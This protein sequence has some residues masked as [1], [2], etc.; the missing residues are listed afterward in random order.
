[1]THLKQSMLFF[2]ITTSF[3]G[4]TLLNSASSANIVLFHIRA[5]VA[6]NSEG[7]SIDD[8]EIVKSLIYASIL[9][10]RIYVVKSCI[11]NF[12]FLFTARLAMTTQ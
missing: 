4:L 12:A 9:G 7:R 5:F 6:V 11:L 8:K 3:S 1:M 10:N 2:N